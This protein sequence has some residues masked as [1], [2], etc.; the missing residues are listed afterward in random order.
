MG[1]D[2]QLKGQDN[3][4]EMMVEIYHYHNIRVLIDAINTSLIFINDVY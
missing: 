2:G 1:S 4:R 3:L